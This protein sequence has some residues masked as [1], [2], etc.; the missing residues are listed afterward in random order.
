MTGLSGSTFSGIDATI[1]R[2]HRLEFAWS[3]CQRD[4]GFLDPHALFSDVRPVARDVPLP[5]ARPLA[6]N[7]VRTWSCRCGDL[8]AVSAPPG[9]PRPQSVRLAATPVAAELIA[10]RTRARRSHSD[11]LPHGAAAPPPP[12]IA[13]CPLADDDLVRKGTAQIHR[14]LSDIRGSGAWRHPSLTTDWAPVGDHVHAGHH[15]HRQRTAIHPRTARPRRTR[16]WSPCR[17]RPI[18]TRYRGET[19]RSARCGPPPSLHHE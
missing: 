3:R 13:R 6:S 2:R 12:S 18:M 19:R 5:R 8:E 4:V 7:R 16:R 17:P 11:A 14:R 1:I 10:I 15:H 9:W